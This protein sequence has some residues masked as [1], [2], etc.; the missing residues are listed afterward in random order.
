MKALV[1]TK[2][3]STEVLRLAE[4][5]KPELGP[6]D[7]LIEVYATA[8]NPVDTK[9]RQHGLGGMLNPPFVLGFDVSGVV[10]EV[11]ANAQSSFA[12][13][14]E[15]F[16][17][18]SIAKNGA[19]AEY[20]AADYRTVAK[21]PAS[22]SHVQAAAMPVALIT[23]WEGLYDRLNIQAGET[24]LIHAG[25]GGVG[26]FAIQLAKLKGARVITTA[27]SATSIEL[28]NSLG[29]DVVINHK[30]EDFV[31]RVN[32]LT[33]NKGVTAIFDCVGGE[34]F[35]RSLDCIAPGGRIATIVEG[36][37]ENPSSKLFF[38]NASVHYVFIGSALLHNRQPET[39]GTILAQAAQLAAEGRLKTHV[40]QVLT[41]EQLAEAHKLQESGR[42]T[43]KIGISVHN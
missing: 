22:I 39:Q 6:N 7:L 5:Q 16:G 24:V 29:A 31:A 10:R 4:I 8:M 17:F 37:T 26:H 34:V 18:L 15:V 25:G 32:E 43:G 14:D 11:G 28:V 33:E 9:A 36:G 12:A 30:Q 20:V 41:L 23:A 1:A 21:K 35:N 40:S 2:L 19:N 3:G 38:K 27:S 13:G 42:V